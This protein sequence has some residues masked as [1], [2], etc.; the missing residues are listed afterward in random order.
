MAADDLVVEKVTKGGE[1]WL[2]LSIDRTSKGMAIWART[3]PQV[4]EFII[5]LNEVGD[6]PIPIDSYSRGWTPGTVNPL[7]VRM[8]TRDI[9]CNYYSLNQVGGQL[10]SRNSPNLSFLRI[11]GVG[12]PEGVRF[13]IGGP[14]S[15]GHITSVKEAVLN[16]SRQLFRDYIVPVHINLRIT[17]TE[18]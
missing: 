5:A 18:I 2:E 1:T 7:M 6:P 15:K 17:S 8:I 13:C 16:A 11:V 3:L 12:T 4:E 10:N 9:D 14:V